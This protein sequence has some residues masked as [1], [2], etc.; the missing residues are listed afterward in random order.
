MCVRFFYYF[1]FER[2]YDIHQESMYFVEKIYTLIKTKRSQKWKIPNSVFER[3]NLCF[4]SY[5]NRKLT[6]K[7]R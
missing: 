2:N 5:K 1:N 7:L 6:V 4:S 3:P